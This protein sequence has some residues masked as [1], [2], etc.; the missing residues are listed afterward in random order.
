MQTA[1]VEAF[2]GRL[3]DECLNENLF[4]NLAEARRIVETWRADYTPHRPQR[5]LD[6]QTPTEFPQRLRSN[7]PAPLEPRIG[8]NPIERKKHERMLHMNGYGSGGNVR[9]STMP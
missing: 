1:F 3:R 6:G 7:R 2:N 5:S 8:Y 9:I 4:G